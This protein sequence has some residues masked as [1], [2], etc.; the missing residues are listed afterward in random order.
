MRHHHLSPFIRFRPTPSPPP[1]SNV[2]LIRRKNLQIFTVWWFSYAGEYNCLVES[3]LP[4]QIQPAAAEEPTSQPDDYTFEKWRSVETWLFLLS[5][6]PYR[7][8][9]LLGWTFFP[10]L[11][12]R[13]FA[14]GNMKVHMQ[15]QEPASQQQ[16][17]PAQHISSSTGR[18]ILH[19]WSDYH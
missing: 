3:Q 9:R 7:F 8:R 4:R 14:Y 5:Q 1:T 11:F 16:T 17:I 13:I 6:K 19:F 2:V 12:Q 15:K 18:I 10:A